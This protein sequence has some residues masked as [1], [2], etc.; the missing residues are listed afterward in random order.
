MSYELM[1][2]FS[3]EVGVGTGVEPVTYGRAAYVAV[4]HQ[5]TKHRH[6]GSLYTDFTQPPGG[7]CSQRYYYR[8]LNLYQ[9]VNAFISFEHQIHVRPEL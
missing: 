8:R 1:Q 7:S 9:S 4:M 6:F 2:A 5:P 3:F